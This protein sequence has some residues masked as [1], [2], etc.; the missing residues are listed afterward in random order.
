MEPSSTNFSLRT[1]LLKDLQQMI[2][3]V[4]ES[5]PN[6]LSLHIQRLSQFA[7]DNASL[8]NPIP[9]PDQLVMI[10]MKQLNETM[11]PSA[12]DLVMNIASNHHRMISCSNDHSAQICEFNS[13]VLSVMD[14]LGIFDNLNA[15]F[16]ELLW[17]TDI[18]NEIHNHFQ[19]I[20]R[21]LIAHKQF[22]STFKFKAFKLLYEILHD[23]RFAPV[24]ETF[25]KLVQENIDELGPGQKSTVATALYNQLSLYKYIKTCWFT[26]A[27]ASKMETEWKDVR[28]IYFGIALFLKKI[29]HLEEY[30]LINL[31]VAYIDIAT[32]YVH[33]KC[34]HITQWSEI[35]L[36]ERLN[37]LFTDPHDKTTFSSYLALQKHNMNELHGGLTTQITAR[38]HAQYY[39]HTNV[40]KEIDTEEDVDLN[41]LLPHEYMCYKNYVRSHLKEIP[42]TRELLRLFSD[43]AV[44]MFDNN[45]VEELLI[46]ARGITELSLNNFDS[47]IALCES[48]I[49]CNNSLVLM[50]DLMHKFNEYADELC[51]LNF[52]LSPNRFFE[53]IKRNRLLLLHC[54]NCG[55]LPKTFALAHY[56]YKTSK[57]YSLYFEP[58]FKELLSSDIFWSEFHTIDITYITPLVQTLEDDILTWFHTIDFSH[59]A[60][61]DPLDDSKFKEVRSKGVSHVPIIQIM[62]SGSVEELIEYV[63]QHNFDLKSPVMNSIFDIDYTEEDNC[64]P[65]T[66]L[67]LAMFYGDILKFKYV[68]STVHGNKI[69]F[70]M[71]PMYHRSLSL[72]CDIIRNPCNYD[73]A[74]SLDMYCVIHGN[75]PEIFHLIEEQNTQL[76]TMFS[77]NATIVDAD[78]FIS[79]LLDEWNLEVTFPVPLSQAERLGIVIARKI[80]IE[81]DEILGHVTFEEQV[82]AVRRLL[83]KDETAPF[84]GKTMEEL[85]VRTE[86]M[87]L[88]KNIASNEAYVTAFRV[89]SRLLMTMQ[90]E[91]HYSKYRLEFIAT[92]NMWTGFPV[93]FDCHSIGAVIENAVNKQVEGLWRTS[94]LIR[95]SLT[96]ASILYA[97]DFRDYMMNN[98][99]PFMNQVFD[100]HAP[101]LSDDFESILPNMSIDMIMKMF[102]NSRQRLQ[103][104]RLSL[105]YHF[106]ITLFTGFNHRQELLDADIAD[107]T[108]DMEAFLI[109]YLGD[110]KKLAYSFI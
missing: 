82:A 4:I 58:E 49:Y 55:V 75:N 45:L 76:R 34:F 60:L 30:R 93:Y 12:F 20:S 7:L 67:Q 89:L 18:N 68:L 44:A 105:G 98:K 95:D 66:Y 28:I 61:I 29:E 81:M 104:F 69:P 88:M 42:V 54:F 38:Q 109:E 59:T 33:E 85:T 80:L 32:K 36:L 77:F 22:C 79:A 27:L 50:L 19:G 65:K 101:L 78:V 106:I 43:K 108:H 35:H 17:I 92:I 16:P 13:R 63:A 1:Q 90:T 86:N 9:N 14:C 25:E 96:I 84:D 71:R 51:Y 10:R 94:N 21:I 39:N 15:F 5:S 23:K 57:L 102:K 74:F 48:M 53:L 64:Y 37:M 46:P 100:R 87:R 73:R 41:A 31:I 99:V 11:F 3:S 62:N 110:A 8:L 47:I 70:T 72:T 24:N 2:I 83:N 52:G 107:E 26:K 6:E 56:M 40:V 91:R 97:R 103:L